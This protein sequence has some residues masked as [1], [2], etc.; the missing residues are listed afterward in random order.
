MLYPAFLLLSLSCFIKHFSLPPPAS[1]TSIQIS[2]SLLSSPSLS[3][4]EVYKVLCLAI[5]QNSSFSYKRRTYKSHSHLVFLSFLLLAAGD[6]SPNPG[7]Y[8]IP[9]ISRPRAPSLRSKFQQYRTLTPIPKNP[10][11]LSCALW[12]ARSVCNKLTA[13]HDHF[14]ANSFNLLAL[15]ETWL[16]PTDTASP[17][18]LS[19]GGL[20]LT[21][22][23][24]PGNRPGGGVGLLLSPRC[25]FK[26]L[27]PVPSLS[28]SSFEAHC[29]RLFSP[30]SLCIAVIYRPP[31][32][33][34]QFLD[35][36]AAW[37]PYFLSSNIPSII[38]G[39][40]NIPVNNINNSSVSKLL[41]LTSSLG[42]SLC[43]DS[44]SHSNGNALDLIFTRLCST[45][46]FTNSPFPLSD[47]NMLTFQLSL[48][49]SSPPA[50]PQTRTYRD[51]QAV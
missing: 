30:V 24:R 17:A 46:N 37:L 34:A 27:P 13:I 40:F 47:H 23:P 44:P 11:N 9:V 19:Y 21:H 22:T 1:P 7:P 12:N 26:V 15:T 6:I 3:T 10:V 16:S 38:L 29:I 4:H 41:S 49:P 35:N 14:I 45:T 8:P 43:S 31:G 2:A 42:L 36:F 33:T 48:T 20:H 25:T 28:F 50:I 39:D 51:L 5:P 32:P 18:A